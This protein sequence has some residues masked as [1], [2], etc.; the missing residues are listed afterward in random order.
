LK[1]TFS[2]VKAKFQSKLLSPNMSDFRCYFIAKDIARGVYFNNPIKNDRFESGF[3]QEKQ[4]WPIFS[5]GGCREQAW[6]HAAGKDSTDALPVAAQRQ[7]WR[8]GTPR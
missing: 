1:G 2:I 4:T 8:Q 7:L 5:M 6:Q 3:S